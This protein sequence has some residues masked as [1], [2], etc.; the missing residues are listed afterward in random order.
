MFKSYKYFKFLGSIHFFSEPRNTS[1]RPFSSATGA[2]ANWLDQARSGTQLSV[3]VLAWFSG[4]GGDTRLF[5][6]DD[7][8]YVIL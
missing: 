4:A 6:V 3:V 5:F 2:L 8:D 7:R 1:R